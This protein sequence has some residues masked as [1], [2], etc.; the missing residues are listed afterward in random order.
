M[1]ED[2]ENLIEVFR[3]IQ[4]HPGDVSGIWW[5]I[6]TMYSVSYNINMLIFELKFILANQYKYFMFRK[7][8][9]YR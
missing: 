1:A 7:S 2:G 4:S 9:S 3:Q 5:C 6:C 8:R